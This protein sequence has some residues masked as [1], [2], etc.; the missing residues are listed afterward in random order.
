MERWTRGNVS[1]SERELVR[2]LSQ[3]LVAEAC[4]VLDEGIAAQPADVDLALTAGV[5]FQSS[6]APALRRLRASA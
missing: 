5:G 2:R 3:P 1:L 4:A 6:I